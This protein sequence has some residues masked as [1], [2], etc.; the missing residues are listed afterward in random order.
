[1]RKALECSKSLSVIRNHGDFELL[2]SRCTIE[3]HT[4][5]AAWGEFALMLE[6]VAAITRLSLVEDKNAM[7]IVLEGHD[8]MTLQLLTS[9]LSSSKTSDHLY[10]IDPIF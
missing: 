3:T 5:M 6:D 9:T 7:A 4:F 1:M 2:L 8:E 10:V